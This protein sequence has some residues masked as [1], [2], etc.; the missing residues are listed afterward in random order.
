MNWYEDPRP[1]EEKRAGE[2]VEDEPDLASD[3]EE[4]SQEEEEEVRRQVAEKIAN[5]KREDMRQVLSRRMEE[6]WI[7]EVCVYEMVAALEEAGVA[8][9]DAALTRLKLWLD[10]AR[11]QICRTGQVLGEAG[12]WLVSVNVGEAEKDWFTSL[13]GWRKLKGAF[14]S[15]PEASKIML[16]SAEK[17]YAAY[18]EAL[19]H[20][21]ESGGCIDEEQN[22]L[23]AA[24]GLQ[25]WMLEQD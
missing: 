22:R 24:F 14:E 6:C 8:A 20:S 7:A 5:M 3:V 4:E 2:G 10:A 17:A 25:K 21:F 16:L 9:E 11:T 1:E 18:A 15:L 23:A 19:D 12:F 13:T